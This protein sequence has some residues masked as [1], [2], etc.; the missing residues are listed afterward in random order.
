M[1]ET[2]ITDFGG[3]IEVMA[4]SGAEVILL[5]AIDLLGEVAGGGAYDDI[6][7]HTER[8]ALFGAELRC[9]SLPMLIAGR[10][11]DL[12]MLAGLEALQEERDRATGG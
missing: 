9:A 2:P 5:G 11:K 6:L 8:V 10:A 12:D 3:V 1:A 7:P 4:R